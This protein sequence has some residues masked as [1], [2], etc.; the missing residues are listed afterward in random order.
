MKH[1]STQ[2]IGMIPARFGSTRFPGKPLVKI[3][4]KTLLQR[5]YENALR[6]SSLTAL[7]V[8]TDD[9]RIFDHVK[10]FGGQAI[11]TDPTCPSGTDRIAEAIN[12]FPELK[13]ANVI[14]NIQGDEPCISPKIINDVADVLAQDP[15]AQMS[16]AVTRLHLKEDA[17]NPSVVKCVIDGSQNAIYFSRAL[18][19]SCKNGQWNP[20]QIYYRHIGIYGYRP[21]FL[22]TYQQ[23]TPSILQMAEDLEQ[24]KALEHGY[25]I[26]VVIGDHESI[27]VD[28]PEDILKVEQWLC[29][30]NTSL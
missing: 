24:L 29:K 8:V 23:L 5:T 16:T 7:I 30:Q 15:L 9:Q 19:P 1:R 22:M 21:P 14:M 25:R 17:E 28:T 11:M 27:G 10:N 2:I 18:I 3:S 26:K 4:G 13:K 6:A 12:A 20:D